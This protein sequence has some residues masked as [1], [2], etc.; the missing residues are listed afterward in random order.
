MPTSPSGGPARAPQAGG[1]FTV[2]GWLVMDME[3]DSCSG[4]PQH[5]NVPCKLVC[6]GAAFQGSTKGHVTPGRRGDCRSPRSSEVMPASSR[7]LTRDS[8]R[9]GLGA[10]GWGR[11]VSLPELHASC[12]PRREQKG[13]REEGQ[14]VTLR[15]LPS[16][17][18]L[19]T[20]ESRARN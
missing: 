18:P 17:G 14:L 12:S 16:P 10:R 4:D 19:V 20:P 9:T 5:P 11:Q 3:P 13:R 1:G 7:G 6:L 2:P 8:S 15:S